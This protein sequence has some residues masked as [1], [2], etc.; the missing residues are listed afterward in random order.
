M[1]KLITKRHQRC[2]RQL[3]NHVAAIHEKVKN[4]KCNE[5]GKEFFYKNNYLTHMKTVHQGVRKFK[6]QICDKPF[7]RLKILQ[8]HCETVHNQILEYNDE[9]MLHQ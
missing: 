3:R 4:V 6:C 2:S 1:H 5:C 9:S 7:D 8:K